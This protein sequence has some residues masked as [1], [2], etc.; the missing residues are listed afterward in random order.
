MIYYFDKNREVCFFD[1]LLQIFLP[2]TFS[3]PRYL[4]SIRLC[5][6]NFI[7]LEIV[8]VICKFTIR[9]EKSLLGG[10][11]G[12]RTSGIEQSDEQIKTKSVV[13]LQPNVC[14]LLARHSMEAWV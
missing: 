6:G 14:Q 2:I 8:M 4:P 5:E 7:I 3:G 12:K 9:H 10:E 1:L 13:I 11:E